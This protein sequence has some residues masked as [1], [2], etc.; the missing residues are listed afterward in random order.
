[1]SSIILKLPSLLLI[2]HGQTY[3]LVQSGPSLP[4]NLDLAR[5]V[6]EMTIQKRSGS[7]CIRE[8]RS[9]SPC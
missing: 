6:S 2:F 9:F 7:E 4:T 5:S 1:M 3:L 8:I